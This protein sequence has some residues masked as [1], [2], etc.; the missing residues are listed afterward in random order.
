MPLPPTW[1]SRFGSIGAV[2]I[3]VAF[4][5]AVLGGGRKR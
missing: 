4:L 2:I 1:Q 5:G 3:A